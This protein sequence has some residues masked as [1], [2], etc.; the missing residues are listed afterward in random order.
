[1]RDEYVFE[2]T[3]VGQY[4][5]KVVQDDDPMNPRTEYDNVGI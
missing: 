2:K 3:K 5:V 4:I 1:M